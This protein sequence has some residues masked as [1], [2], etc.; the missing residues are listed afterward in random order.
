MLGLSGGALAYSVTLLNKATGYIGDAQ[1][2]L[3][4]ADCLL[5]LVSIATGVWFTL[6]RVR[7]FDLTS[8]IARLRE[9]KPECAQ[10]ETVRDR[11]RRLGR[12]T[13][14]LFWSQGLT[15]I[16]G[17]AAFMAFVMVHYSH[18]IYALKPV[19]QR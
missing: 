5:Q 19:A 14:R 1:S 9:R 10:L 3:F 8:Q 7:D 12:R 15:F 16:L 6:N 2:V 18:V 4:H 13:R 17:A 11:V